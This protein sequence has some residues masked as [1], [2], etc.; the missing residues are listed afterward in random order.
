MSVELE[1][2]SVQVDDMTWLLWSTL[3]VAH[4]PPS[5]LVEVRK[6]EWEN[7]PIMETLA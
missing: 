6:V 7:L 4:R 5:V 2:I 3:S 1:V